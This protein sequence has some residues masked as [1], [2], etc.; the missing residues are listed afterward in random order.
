MSKDSTTQR[1]LFPGVFRKP[2]VAQFDRREGRSDDGAL[3]LKAAIDTMTWWPVY[4]RRANEI[5]KTR[6]GPPPA[7]STSS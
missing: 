2:V 6:R 5:L 3:L 7:N 1:L 4:F